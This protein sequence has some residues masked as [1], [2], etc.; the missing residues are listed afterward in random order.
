MNLLLFDP[1]ELAAGAGG[2]TL[3]AGD[4]RA[5]HLVAVLRARVGQVLRAGVAGGATGSAEVLAIA[6]GAV[7]L[8]VALDGPASPRPPV[9]LVLAV[10]RPKALA[11]ALQTAAALGVGRIDLV[12]AWRVDR[13]YFS[14]PQ[15]APAALAEAVRLGCEQ[16]G[17]TWLPEVAVHP[18][19]MPFLRASAPG[20]SGRRLLL[21]HPR[22]GVRLEEVARPGEGGPALLAIGPEGGWIEREVETFAGLGFSPVSLGDAVLRVEAAIAALLAQLELLRRLGPA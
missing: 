4:R 8:R 10:P 17:T 21:A 2:V 19:L 3:A 1:A 16:G 22:A 20:W 7:T 14:S 5:R 9:D 13:A 15:L 6:G 12:N 11:R 18:L